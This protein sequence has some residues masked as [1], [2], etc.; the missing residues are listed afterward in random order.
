MKLEIRDIKDLKSNPYQ[1]RIANIENIDTVELGQSIRDLNLEGPG[2]TSSNHKELKELG[3]SILENGLLQPIVID[4]DNIIIAGHR[5]VAACKLM[6]IDRIKCLVVK[7]KNDDE[8]L[9]Y[10]I[11][12]N[13]QRVD[14]TVIEY[15][16]ALK[17]LQIKMNI[18]Q[19][20]ISFIIKKSPGTVSKYLS[21][22]TLHDDIQNDIIDNHRIVNRVVLDR[23]AAMPKSLYKSQ[24]DIYFKFINDE[25]NNHEAI[26]LINEKLNKYYNDDSLFNLD[27]VVSFSKTGLSIKNIVVPKDKRDIIQKEIMKIIEDNLSKK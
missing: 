19:S 12:E 23:L 22:L 6:N 15:A 16:M 5:R 26:F 11:L 21:L 3:E 27:P 4:I 8:R 7:I 10:N 20:E 24:K 14:L 2:Y 1:T 25:I 13:I 18:P 9:V 17:Q